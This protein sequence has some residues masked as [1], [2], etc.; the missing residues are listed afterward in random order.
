MRIR[1]LGPGDVAAACALDRLFGELFED[2]ESDADRPQPDVWVEGLLER[3][4]FVMLVAEDGGTLVGGLL[5]YVLDS[6]EE[7]R[8]QMY[9][10]DLGVA[11]SHRRRG[12]ATALIANLQALAA[13]IG[14]ADL[15]VQADPEDAPA[16]ALYRGLGTGRAV[17]HF[18]IPP[19]RRV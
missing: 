18:D 3:A 19:R 7:A 12:I 6:L 1:R 4:D 15:Y 10:Y 11:G 16:L 5:A 8:R 13:E 2:R 14:A 17:F 9:L